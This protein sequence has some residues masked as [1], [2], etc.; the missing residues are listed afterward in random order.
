MAGH[1]DGIYHYTSVNIPS[2]V[3]VTFIPNANN[4]PVVWLVQAGC[5]IAGL[6][7][8]NGGIS[9]NAPI[10]ALGGPGGYAGG[11]GATAGNI[12]GDGLGPGGGHSGTN[13]ASGNGSFGTVGALGNYWCPQQ[14]APGPIYGNAYLVPL[15]GGSGGGGPGGGGGGAILI[16][17]SSN[18][19][20]TGQIHADGGNGFLQTCWN[21]VLGGGG[22]GSGGAIRLVSTSV[23][24]N[25][26][27]SAGGG[28]SYVCWYDGV[29]SSVA[30]L[31]RVR[32]DS[33][34]DTFGGSINANFSRGY[35]PIIIPQN[36]QVASLIIQSVGGVAV[37][38]TPSGALATPDAVLS[39]QQNNPIPIVIQCSNL[40]LH[41]PITVTVKPANGLSVT[42]S[43][44]NSVGTIASSVATISMVM[45]RGGGLI[46]ATVAASN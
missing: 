34:S 24:G 19:T 15:L 20:V 23:T 17:A 29:A 40:P 39:A 37:S 12:A 8:V 45:P 5:N 38:A 10:G 21:C 32:I 30:G 35:Q 22:G 25:G 42:A 14:N 41:T 31:G 11:T 44:F 1:P 26:Y 46:H 6:V 4:T 18:I 27:L 13:G 43:G 9:S 36:N 7:S 3:T 16:A 2:G 33:F 28:S